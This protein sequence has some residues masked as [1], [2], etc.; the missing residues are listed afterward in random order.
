LLQPLLSTSASSGS[1]ATLLKLLKTLLDLDPAFTLSPS[2]NPAFEFIL[3]AYSHLLSPQQPGRT[4]A[5]QQQQLV[6]EALKLL[7]T[8]LVQLQHQQQLLRG[9]QQ[10]DVSAALNQLVNVSFQE[11]SASCGAAAGH[12]QQ[13]VLV[14]VV[15]GWGV[16]NSTIRR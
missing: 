4:R 10:E 1:Q 16:D 5:V 7:G 12:E 15:N 13:C 11:S 8:V 14:E 6:T 9:Q 3:S 2:R